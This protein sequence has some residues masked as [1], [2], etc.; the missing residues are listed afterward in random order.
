MWL[1]NFT[2]SSANL[3]GDAKVDKYLSSILLL[4]LLDGKGWLYYLELMQETNSL[5]INLTVGSPIDYHGPE[6][7]R[8]L[9]A[10]SPDNVLS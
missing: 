6:E 7:T 10:E 4:A 5:K 8:A 2:C 3:G 1:S 9:V